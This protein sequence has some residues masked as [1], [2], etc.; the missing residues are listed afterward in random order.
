MFLLCCCSCYLKCPSCLL[1]A[2]SCY[3]NT[4]CIRRRILARQHYEKDL[5]KEECETEMQPMLAQGTDQS[6]PQNPP[7]VPQTSQ[8]P[9]IIRPQQPPYNPNPYTKWANCKNN[10]L[11]CSCLATGLPCPHDIVFVRWSI[12][13]QNILSTSYLHFQH[14]QIAFS[15]SLRAFPDWKKYKMFHYF[16]QTTSNFEKFPLANTTKIYCTW[17]WMSSPFLPFSATMSLAQK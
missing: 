5:A 2:F 15:N 7:P 3:S 11:T 13:N 10:V 1:Y 17:L 8:A 9:P 12:Y 6:V 14:L 16:S 4:C